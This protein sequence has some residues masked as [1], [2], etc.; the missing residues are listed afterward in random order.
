MERIETVLTIKVVYSSSGLNNCEQSSRS[1]GLA[2]SCRAPQ[3]FSLV[4][5]EKP[6]APAGQDG[7]ACARSCVIRNATQALQCRTGAVLTH[8]RS[9]SKGSNARYLTIGWQPWTP[10]WV[11]HEPSGFQVTAIKRGITQCVR[12]ATHANQETTSCGWPTSAAPNHL[13]CRRRWTHGVDEPGGKD[14]TP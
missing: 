1:Q 3:A 9:D 4:L 10:H 12:R 5:R 14:S 8:P 2:M 13:C 6:A 7:I 11:I